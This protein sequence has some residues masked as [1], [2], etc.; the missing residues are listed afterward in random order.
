DVDRLE[1][2]V[3]PVVQR[4][5]VTYYLLDKPGSCKSLEYAR[6]T[7][8]DPANC[9]GYVQFD[10]Q[11]RA[12]FNDVKAAVEGS[13]VDVERIYQYEGAIYVELPD[14]SWQYNYFYVYLPNGGSPPTPN[15]PEEKWTH[16]RGNW[17]FF[18]GHDD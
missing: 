5:G 10:D 14:S 8:S 18:L 15:F 2:D 17:W 1:K 9:S 11:A 16:I 3:I 4:L 7:Y 6:G 13:N 12:D